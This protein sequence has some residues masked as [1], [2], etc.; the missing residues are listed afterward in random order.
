MDGEGDLQVEFAGQRMCWWAVSDRGRAWA[1][2]HGDLLELAPEG[3]EC[4]V[5]HG[6]AVLAEAIDSGLVVMAGDLEVSRC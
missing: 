5:R 3:V 2:A 6:D 1:D 4:L